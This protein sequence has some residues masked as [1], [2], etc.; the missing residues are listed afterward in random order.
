MRGRLPRST[1]RGIKSRSL[2]PANRRR[3]VNFGR[4]RGG[5]EAQA[6]ARACR[7]TRCR[8]RQNR[9]Q[10]RFVD[11]GQEL[12]SE[13]DHQPGGKPE[14]V[15]GGAE[16]SRVQGIAL[17]TPGDSRN[18][19]VIKTPAYCCGKR[20]IGIRIPGRAIIRVPRTHQEMG[21]GRELSDGNR[22][23]RPEQERIGFDIYFEIAANVDRACLQVLRPI[24]AAE[25]GDNANPGHKLPLERTFPTVQAR[26][27]RSRK[28][29]GRVQYRISARIRISE[30]NIPAGGNLCLRKRRG[31]SNARQE[32]DLVHRVFS[33]GNSTP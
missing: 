31:K 17:Q 2:R 22:Y 32:R 10:T 19:L 30:E 7:G 23:S 5:C 8:N 3:S 13:P 4:S 28:I 29:N 33:S 12:S 26:T 16:K 21:K 6:I 15:L 27:L 25:V 1:S 24:A 18:Q 9:S 14:I 11:S 20:G